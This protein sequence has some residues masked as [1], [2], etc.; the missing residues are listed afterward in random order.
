MATKEIKKWLV[1]NGLR[2]P[3]I[4]SYN[5]EGMTLAPGERRSITNPNFLGPL[6]NGV[7]CV[8]V[9]K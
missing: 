6:P 3:V 9:L 2:H 1:V 8:P 4:L 7:R 5:G